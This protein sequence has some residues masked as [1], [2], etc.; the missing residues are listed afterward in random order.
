MNVSLPDALKA[1]VD[2]QVATRAFGTISEYIRE[3]IRD[4]RDRQHLR[5]L[6]VQGASSAPTE[7]V[8]DNYFESLRQRVRSVQAR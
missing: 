1:F 2:E 4:D 3:L 6:L 7:P 8:D 5:S